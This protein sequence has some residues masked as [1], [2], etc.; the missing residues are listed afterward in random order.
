MGFDAF[1][2]DLLNDGRVR[3][4]PPEALP[5]DQRRAAQQTLVEFEAQYRRELPHHPPPLDLPAANWAAERLLRACQFAVFRDLPADAI[6][7]EAAQQLHGEKTPTVH[8]AVD[9]VFR[10]LPDL[11]RLARRAAEQDPL[12]DYLQLLARSWPLSSVGMEIKG[13]LDAEAFL[14][15]ACLRRLYVD[16]ILAADDPTRLVDARVVDGVK[17]AVG[18]HFETPPKLSRALSQAE[19]SVASA[20]TPGDAATFPEEPE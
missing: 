11:L 16:R 1:L 4:P 3:V 14:D 2:R 20:E 18:R 19:L 5:Q 17:A 9:L 12:V 10:F 6:A 8:Y 13:E 15:D 7:H